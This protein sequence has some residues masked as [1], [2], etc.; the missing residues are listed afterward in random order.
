MGDKNK[1]ATRKAFA[2]RFRKSLKELGYSTNEQKALQQLFD[3][4]G[5]AV[6][7]WIDGES[8]PTS[9]RIPHI[10]ETLGVRRA[11]LQDGEEP[12]R[13]VIG[14]IIGQHEGN[15]EISLSAIDANLLRKYRAL[16]PKQRKAVF[17]IV[18]LLLEAGK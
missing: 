13:P 12:M 7:K 6:R 14:N 18:E 8:L 16:S 5:Q 10:A 4:S 15:D 3:V 9:S 11:W 2:A 17:S 1:D